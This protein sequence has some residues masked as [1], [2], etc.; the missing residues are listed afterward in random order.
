MIQ[1]SQI[2]ELLLAEMF[3]GS[4]K[5][6]QL[7]VEKGLLYTITM[8][9]LRAIP[10]VQLT[11][12]GKYRFDGAHKVDVVVIVQSKRECIAIEV[13]LG[14]DRLGKHE[15]EKRFLK[16]C[17]KSHGERRISGSMIAILEG[18]L[19]A[20]CENEP[21]VV[22]YRGAIYHLVPQ[23]ALVV[24]RR[25]LDAWGKNGRPAFSE[26]CVPLSFESVVSRYGGRGPF[27]ALV[28]KLACGD[29]YREWIEEA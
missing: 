19:P 5:V 11:R 22:N 3:N 17:G 21:I 7:F 1:L 2:G 10:E 8:T 18:K 27:N 13:K 4:E 9:D 16:R 12:C 20:S 15:F 28:S 24:R 14:F 6:R 26:K 29:Y 23:W 25:V